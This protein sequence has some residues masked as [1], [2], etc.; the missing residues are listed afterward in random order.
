MGRSRSDD[1]NPLRV[2][3]NERKKGRGLWKVDHYFDVYHRHFEPF[4]GTDV[5]VLEIGVGS[6]GSLDMWHEYFGP[7]ARVY[8]VDLQEACLRYADDSTFIF[9]GDQGDRDFWRAFRAEVPNLDIVVDDGAHEPLLQTTSFEELFPHL[10]PGGVY[11]V[12]DHLGSTN[13]FP[14]YASGLVRALNAW[15]GTS[16]YENPERRKVSPAEGFQSLVDSI[17]SYP[18]ATVVERRSETIVESVAPKHGTE[19]EPFVR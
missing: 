3:F 13:N 19:W 1:Q 5:H 4:R 11:L 17:H 12:E 16:D 2:F 6:G 10:R 7:R 9:I 15:Q 8:G 18:F 14:A